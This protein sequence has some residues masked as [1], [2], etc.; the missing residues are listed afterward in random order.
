MIDACTLSHVHI[1]VLI[2]SIITM[3]CSAD[4][5][6]FVLHFYPGEFLSVNIVGTVLFFS[7]VLWCILGLVI[8]FC[9]SHLARLYLVCVCVIPC[10]H[11]QFDKKINV[12]ILEE[13]KEIEK[14]VK[15]KMTS[16]EEQDLGTSL[17]PGVTEEEETTH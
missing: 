17:L 4:G 2:T 7:T 1:H 3:S 9:V 13:L 12:A 5:F 10:A 14:R 16:V 6:S 8:H 11:L 15:N